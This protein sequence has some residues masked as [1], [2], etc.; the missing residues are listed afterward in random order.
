VDREFDRDRQLPHDTTVLGAIRQHPLAV[1]LVTALAAAVALGYHSTRPSEYEGKASLLAPPPAGTQSGNGVT[2]G[3]YVADQVAI[4]QSQTLA[5]EAARL[6]NQQMPSAAVTATSIQR[7]ASF[8]TNADSDLIVITFRSPRAEVARLAADAI[9]RAYEESPSPDATNS[10]AQLNAAIASLDKQLTELSNLQNSHKPASSGNAVSKQALHDEQQSVLAS[11]AKLVNDRQQAE[12]NAALAS[13]RVLFFPAAKPAVA[14]KDNLPRLVAV[15]LV[16][17]VLAG[18]GLA[19][20]LAVSRRTVR[21][22]GEAAAILD[23]PLL[24]QIPSFE[25]SLDPY[26]LPICA[27]PTGK[28]AEAFRFTASTLLAQST[29][30]PEGHSAAVLVVVSPRTGDGKTTSAANIGIA[31]AAQGARVLLVD[32]DARANGLTDLLVDD[33][34]P[35]PGRLTTLA[36]PDGSVLDLLRLHAA[37]GQPSRGVRSAAIRAL[38]LSAAT[39]HDLILFD[40]PPLLHVSDAAAIAAFAQAALVVVRHRASLS[41]LREVASRLELLGLDSRGYVYNARRPWGRTSAKPRGVKANSAGHVVPA[42][43]LTA[44]DED[45][46]E[47][48]SSADA[49]PGPAAG[50]RVSSTVITYPASG[51]RSASRLP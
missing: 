18:I 5:T 38:L 39:T 32:A 8:T 15:A 21:R 51:G 36:L 2:P 22:R 44:A 45:V 47:E 27:A 19:Y 28:A 50:E 33:E 17:G 1:V 23:A 29:A 11:R 40:T 4:L 30:R 10:V 12:A 46:E 6:V 7:G 48:A 31:A 49:A 9:G 43:V 26:G 34:W 42:R 25:A 24:A 35:P 14:T 37:E 16:L 41:D 20:L 3:R 13:G